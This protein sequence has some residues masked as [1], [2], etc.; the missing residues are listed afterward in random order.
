[1]LQINVLTHRRL[2]L[3]LEVTTHSFEKFTLY[4]IYIY[5]YYIYIYTVSYHYHV[6]VYIWLAHMGQNPSVLKPLIKQAENSNLISHQKCWHLYGGEDSEWVNDLW[7]W[8]LCHA[9]GYEFLTNCIK[10]SPG[11]LHPSAGVPLR[12]IKMQEGWTESP[13]EDI[14]NLVIL[15]VRTAVTHTGKSLPI[16]QQLRRQ[17]DSWWKSKANWN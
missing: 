12:C 10:V 3:R 5:I 7:D 1:M 6:L 4:T 17:A 16:A 11:R 9:G 13:K 15:M 8:T 2:H 14:N